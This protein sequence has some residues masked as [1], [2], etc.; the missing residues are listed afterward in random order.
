MRFNRITAAFFAIL[1]IA[2]T[3]LTSVS[4]AGVP[5][6]VDG[7]RLSEKMAAKSYRATDGMELNYRMYRSPGYDVGVDT[8]PAILVFYFHND[9]GKGDDNTAQLAERGLLNQLVADSSDIMFSSYQ[10][11]VV[12]PQCPEGK[13]F[14]DGDITAAVDELRQELR[15]TEIITEKCIVMG[16]GSGADGAFEYASRFTESV[17]RLVTVGGAP[18]K[19]K[20]FGS[21]ASGVTMLCFAEKSNAAMNQFYDYAETMGE[22]GYITAVFTDG[23]LSS[24]V[25]A[26]LA[27]SDPSVTEWVVKDAYESRYFTIHARCTEGGGKISVSPENVKYGG[28]ASVVLTV[29]KGYVIDR[30]VVD[31]NDEDIAKLE[32]AANNKNQYIYNFMGVTAEHS[33]MVELVAVPTSGDKADL[34]D[35]LITWLSVAAAVLVLAAAAVCA[36]SLVKK[37]KA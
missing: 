26:A 31:S 30:L 13:S 21:L 8:K 34:I 5:T 3:V 28:N 12:A 25:N 33:V 36:V 23:D 11:I 16:V 19:L 10:Y 37:H 2:L 15:A 6:E 24:S 32:Q 7:L 14:T 35:G 9:S 27:Y 18:D 1:I 22:S 29:N 4:A 20:A 17:S